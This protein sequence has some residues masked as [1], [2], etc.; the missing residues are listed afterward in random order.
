MN[1]YTRYYTDQ[2]GNGLSGFEGYRFQKGYGFFGRIFK[3]FAK[4]LLGYLGKKAMSTGRDIVGDVLSG[5]NFKESSKRRMLDTLGDM[6]S[7]AKKRF[8]QTGSGFPCKTIK[9]RTRS[10][11]RTVKRKPA[12][13]RVKRRKKKTVKRKPVKRR[14]KKI[15][16]FLD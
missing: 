16:S 6:G 15:P 1:S 5:K 2:A 7:D 11:K 12:K 3:S 10:T 8:T 9:R 14:K 13:R 4:P